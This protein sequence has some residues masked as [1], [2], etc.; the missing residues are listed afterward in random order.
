M[1]TTPVAEPPP[2]A[3]TV[4]ISN[5]MVDDL[6]SW[7][8]DKIYKFEIPITD[9]S[10]VIK[11]TTRHSPR[12]VG[13]YWVLRQ[14]DF[15]QAGDA[16]EELHYKLIRYHTG[17]MTDVETSHW[18]YEK[19]YYATIYEAN[20][21]PWRDYIPS[22]DSLAVF[23]VTRRYRYPFPL[24]NRVFFHAGY[25][26]KR[27]QEL[28]VT[29]LPLQPY[30]ANSDT[31]GRYKLVDRIRYD[32]KNKRLTWEFVSAVH[33]G[34]FVPDALMKLTLSPI[35]ARDVPAFFKWASKQD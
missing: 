3:S 19:D 15:S 6:L 2:L 31:V 25:V 22:D 1:D 9:G 29:Q 18:G 35:I 32:P 17:S 21:E 14:V 23:R 28:I 11:V 13:E 27:D 4:A 7:K 20:I 30:G 5:Q 8:I 24:S 10:T 33:P 12:S 16:V 26:S 34:G